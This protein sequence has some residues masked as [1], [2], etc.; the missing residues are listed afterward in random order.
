LS[1]N[2]F[3]E[4]KEMETRLRSILTLLLFIFLA[5]IANAQK[6]QAIHNAADP[7]LEYLNIKIV[8]PLIPEYE[9]DSVKFRSATPMIDVPLP[10]FNITIQI[11]KTNGEQVYSFNITLE[12]GKTYIGVL[13]GV[14]TPSNFAPNPDGI[15][16]ELDISLIDTGRELATTAG[17]VD[18]F[19]MHGTTDLQTIDMKEQGGS[20]L[21]NDVA[22]GNISD[23]VTVPASSHIFEVSEANG[24]SIISTHSA[25]FSNLADSAVTV[26]ASGFMNPASNQNGEP[27]GLYLVTP[28]GKLIELTP[29]TS[30]SDKKNTVVTDFNLSQNFPNPFNPGTVIFYQ[31][32]KAAGVELKIYNFLGQSVRNLVQKQQA[33]GRYEVAWD[34][35]DDTGR[36]VPS[37]MYIYQI[38]A[39]DYQ[40]AK[41]MI[42]LK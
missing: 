40:A 15:N 20:V 41:R 31:I 30:I 33:A 26:F 14:D 35:L 2:F 4:N 27:Y 6:I 24:S 18:F 21:F 28:S 3:S 8:V 23:Y 17:T 37:G 36:S 19:L 25:D 11:F 39:G 29:P 5:T 22:Y 32:P 38:T 9:I 34:G 13:R 10:G 42:L 7:D 12:S 1:F 16:T